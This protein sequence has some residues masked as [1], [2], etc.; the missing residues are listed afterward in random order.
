VRPEL[1][2]N[3]RLLCERLA[4]DSVNR[5][6][7]A[8]LR[9]TPASDLSLGHI[10][11]LELLELIKTAGISVIYD[12]GA[13]I[14]TWTLLAKAVIPAAY[15]HA[16]EPLPK[17]QDAFDDSLA[18]VHDVTLHRVALG[19]ENEK[20]VLYVT[21]FSDASSMLRPAPKS[22]A[23]FGVR[24]AGQLS[25]RTHRLDDFRSANKLPGPDLIKLDV[26]GYELEVLQ[27]AI[28][29]LTSARA[30]ITEVSFVECYEAQPLFSDVVRFMADHGFHA[31]ALSTT[32]ALGRPLLQTDMLFVAANR[33]PTIT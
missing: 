6:R 24:Q 17:H 26:Q 18:D 15:V 23:H 3:P 16:F 7:L 27:G 28:E 10:D 13:N 1:L 11:S 33:G 21:D 9:N 12:I 32:T 4:I 2:Y 19:S 29:C 8:R 30:V 25:M 5:R 22:Q 20:A 31:R 14:G